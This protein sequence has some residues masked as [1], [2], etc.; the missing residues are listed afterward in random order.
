MVWMD[1]FAVGFCCSCIADNVAYKTDTKEMNNY[2]MKISKIRFYDW[3]AYFLLFIGG[4]N[5]S[6]IAL[7]DFNLIEKIISLTAPI[8]TVTFEYIKT[9]VYIIIGIS[10]IYFIYN[11]N[12]LRS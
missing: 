3:I 4:I 2:R 11:L 9:I 7:F 12:K 5:Y 1:F 8:Y 10:A 6:L